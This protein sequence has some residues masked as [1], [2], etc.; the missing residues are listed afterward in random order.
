MIKISQIKN[1][2]FQKSCK[3]RLASC[4]ELKPSQIWV[5]ETLYFVTKLFVS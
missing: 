3:D 4:S 5:N 1:K 2:Y